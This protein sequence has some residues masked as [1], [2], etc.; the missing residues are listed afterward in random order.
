MKRIRPDKNVCSINDCFNIKN[1]DM[2]LHSTKQGVKSH[3]FDNIQQSFRV[4]IRNSRETRKEG[5]RKVRKLPQSDRISAKEPL[6]K[7]E[8]LK[9]FS[10]RSGIRQDVLH[11]RLYLTLHHYTEVSARA[12][13]QKRSNWC[14]EWKGGNKTVII[15]NTIVFIES[16]SNVQINSQNE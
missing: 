11:H 5:Y 6:P 16:Q 10:L 12:K 1:Q 2:L 8:I 7:C 9:A 4:I 14:E 13:C 15:E 3:T